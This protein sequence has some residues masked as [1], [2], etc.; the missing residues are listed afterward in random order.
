[1]SLGVSHPHPTQKIESEGTPL[2]GQVGSSSSDASIHTDENEKLIITSTKLIPLQFANN[3][4]NDVGIRVTDVALNQGSASRLTDEDLHNLSVDALCHFQRF[5][6]LAALQLAVSITRELVR[7]TPP[8]DDRYCARLGILGFALLCHFEH[9]G[10]QA[11]LEDAISRQREAADLTPDGH[12]DKPGHLNNLGNSLRNRFERLGELNDLE[13]AI[14]KQR[15]AVDLT[16][17]GRP[18][19]LGRLQNL[20]VSFLTRFMHLGQLNDLEDAILR[21][22]EAVDLTPDGHPEKPRVF[23]TLATPSSLVSSA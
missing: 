15:Q 20:G 17:D 19:K 11:D 14:S 13:D 21:Q 7:S 1:M 5:G 22:R 16:P 6:D 9:F 2:A 4:N 3:I 23:K 8:R 18:D 10:D 12:P